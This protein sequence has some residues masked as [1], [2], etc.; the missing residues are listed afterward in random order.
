[1]LLPDLISAH[2][3]AH[4]TRRPA[5]W[6]SRAIDNSTRLFAVHGTETATALRQRRYGTALWTR[7]YG[8]GY[9]NGYA[10]T[11]ERKRDAG[12]QG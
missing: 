12:N 8:N 1:L 11:F 10:W 5:H 9:G 6:A 3:E 2:S 4:E 7:F